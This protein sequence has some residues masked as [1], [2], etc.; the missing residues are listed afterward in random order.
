MKYW[1]PFGIDDPDA[2]YING[3]PSIGR[4][5]S[6]PPAEAFE[7]DMREIINVIKGNALTPSEFDLTQLLVAARSQRMN[8]AV[9]TN[10]A[11]NAIA[12][13]FYPPIN[14]TM[15]PGMPLRI[16]PPLSVTGPCTLI[17]DNVARPLRRA[18]GAELAANDIL[19][20]I[21]FEC[22]WN[23]AGYWIVT[24]FRGLGGVLGGDTINNVYVTKIP[25][26]T[27]HGAPNH[28]IANF[29]PP[30]TA[31]IPGDAIEVRLANNI[32]GPC[33]ITING[34]PEVAVTRP[35]GTPMIN[36]DGV[37]DQIALMLRANNGTWQFTGVVP[38]AASRFFL[39]VGSVLISMSNLAV[40]GTIKLNG[41]MLNRSEHPTLWTVA[42]ASARIVDEAI[43]QA[44][45]Q[46]SWTSFSRGDGATTFRLPDFRAEFP[47]WWDDGRNQDVGRVLGVQQP[48]DFRLHKH[49]LII[50]GNYWLAGGQAAVTGE[51]GSKQVPWPGGGLDIQMLPVG[52]P[53]TRPRNCAL[54]PC[55][56]DG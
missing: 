34:L 54:V 50:T 4:A 2:S 5:G 24:S 25:Y 36:G 12:V 26:T 39:P 27:D 49:E 45:A 1:Q 40:P 35:N 28:I 15:T 13:T 17:V 51:S 38:I 30:I 9:A 18:D 46:R 11:P 56:V 20:N 21:P 10:T 53:E 22:M 42:N 41:A 8:Y 19:A 44:T 47:R 55:I 52:G 31:P 29:T 33:G 23:D 3:D 37:V 48:D 14:D 43:W 7:H 6:I 16:K 32:T